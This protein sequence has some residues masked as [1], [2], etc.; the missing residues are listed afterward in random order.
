MKIAILS[1]EY[2]PD[3]GYGGIGTYSY[4]QA[5]ALAKLGHDVH[6]FAGSHTLGIQHSEHDGVRVTRVKMDGW[7][8]RALQGFRDRRCWW[9][10]NRAETAIAA[11]HAL[12]KAMKREQFDIVEF[13]ECGA[14]GALVTTLLDVPTAIKF[15]SPARL[16]MGIY[17]V[18]RM[19]REVTSFF[20]QIAINQCTV[21]TSCSRFLADEVAAHMHVK[22]PI[23]VVPNGIDLEL[24]DAD[25]GIDVHEK[26]GLPRDP[27][28]LVVFFANRLEERKGVHLVRDMCFAV[29]KKYPHVHFAF[30]GADQFG[31]MERE[32]RPFIQANGLQSRFHYYGRLQLHEVRAILKHVDVF[33]IPSLWENA[34]YSC[35]EAMS[36]GRAIVASDCGGL[37]ELVQHE[38]TGLLARNN[39][40]PSFVAALERMIEDAPLRDRVG[41]AARRAVEERYT[42]VRIAGMAA[43]LYARELAAL[44]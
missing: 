13:P 42:D 8:H 11:F 41:A 37:P 40:G 9:G 4:Y 15:H 33:L 43:D 31:Y 23:H 26:F 20:E 34:P 7:T 22:Q 18:P 28:S 29:M 17:D 19:D 3:T 14:D 10:A 44:A 1:Y 21:R 36:A 2:P 32:I 38:E 30:A 24:F 39:Q 35:I 5:R 27:D 12:K 6:V 25:E 16:I